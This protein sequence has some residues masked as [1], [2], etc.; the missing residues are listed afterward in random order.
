MKTELCGIRDEDDLRKVLAA[1]PDAVGLLLGRRHASSDFISVQTAQRLL[2][3]LPPFVEPVLITHLADPEEILALFHAV[4][5]TT[6]QLHGDTTP[7][8][9]RRLREA[10]PASVKLMKTVYLSPDKGFPEY[11]AYLPHADAFF[12]DSRN[13]E[14]DQVGGTG[15]TNDWN[16]AARFVENSP[17]P[18]MLAGGLTPENVAEAIRIVRPYGVDA[19]TGLRD[20]T[21][22]SRIDPDRCRR[23]VQEARSA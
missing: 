17:V 6:I 18:V 20:R 14:T 22:P 13:P 2:A 23:F 4:G 8:Q 19:N 5:P 21:N 12:I 7:E 1:D 9:A 11:S 16:L 10:L 15:L 3:L